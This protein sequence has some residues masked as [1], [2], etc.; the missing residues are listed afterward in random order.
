MI[1]Q[2]KNTILS[3]YDEKADRV[4]TIARAYAYRRRRNIAHTAHTVHRLEAAV[5]DL[6]DRPRGSDTERAARLLTELRA[7][8][9]A[10]RPFAH[11]SES[12][13]VI[14]PAYERARRAIARAEGTW[15]ALRFTNRPP[16]EPVAEQPQ[17]PLA[18]T[19]RPPP[20]R[21]D[22]NPLER[23]RQ[24]IIAA[25]KRGARAA[26]L[27]SIVMTHGGRTA[28][29]D[30]RG[31]GPSLKAL[32]PEKYAAVIAEVEALPLRHT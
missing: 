27:Q 20:R 21:R 24:T 26:V 31:D 11:M 17:Q 18:S 16:P 1:L 9:D 5:S 12:V 8:A 22:P 7:L 2:N 23:L 15:R 6:L 3:S 19:P 25:Q 28:R 29:P 13:E 30:G 4:A 14:G 10:V 32:P